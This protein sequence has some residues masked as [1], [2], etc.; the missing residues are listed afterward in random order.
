MTHFFL[1]AECGNTDIEFRIL[2]TI[3]KQ[4]LRNKVGVLNSD[5]FRRSQGE[6]RGTTLFER[7]TL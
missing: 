1:K 3:S 2:L 5:S 7:E 6:L 4:P